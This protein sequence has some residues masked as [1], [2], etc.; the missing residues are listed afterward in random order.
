MRPPKETC[1]EYPPCQECLHRNGP[2]PEED[3]DPTPLSARILLSVL[4]ALSVG[5]TFLGFVVTC[6]WAVD[7][8][9][10]VS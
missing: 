1:T 4:V 6:A 8:I 2:A 9:R 5:F 7:L 3:L 10:R